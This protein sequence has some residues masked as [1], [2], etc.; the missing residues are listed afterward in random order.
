MPSNT[1]RS[2]VSGE[3]AP[4]PNSEGSG[5]GGFASRAIARHGRARDTDVPSLTPDDDQFDGFAPRDQGFS[6]LRTPRQTLAW[7]LR[8]APF[9]LRPRDGTLP[10]R[11]ATKTEPET[12]RRGRHRDGTTPAILRGLWTTSVTVATVGATVTVLLLAGIAVVTVGVQLSSLTSG[13]G[14][15]PLRLSGYVESFAHLRAPG[16]G[17]HQNVGSY[18]RY[19]TCIAVTLLV[20]ISAVVRV[21]RVVTSRRY[22]RRRARAAHSLAK[23]T[24]SLTRNAEIEQAKARFDDAV[25]APPKRGA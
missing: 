11:S 22:R 17:W 6:L 21:V 18:W 23:S 9:N 25:A 20:T 7:Y 19:W 24:M 16:V 2:G 3:A 15:M 4:N 1:A 5:S 8:A 13:H 10:R 14:V 12:K